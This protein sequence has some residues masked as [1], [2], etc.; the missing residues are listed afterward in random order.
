MPGSLQRSATRDERRL[1]ELD[2][3]QANTSLDLSAMPRGIVGWH[4]RVTSVP[5]FAGNALRSIASF[6]GNIQNGRKYR[7]FA[8]VPV[9]SDGTVDH[10]V[11][12][13]FSYYTIDG[14]EP[15]TASTLFSQTGNTQILMGGY[16]SE[17]VM[18]N[19]LYTS[20]MAANFVGVDVIPVRFLI[21]LKGLTAS[22][23]YH[24]FGSATWPM[25][26][27]LIDEGLDNT[28]QSEGRDY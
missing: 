2:R 11:I 21:A 20:D 27:Y 7:L 18:D 17:C 26:F 25:E 19:M 10:D 3:K 13:M 22:V 1:R 24:A 4:K 12:N 5:G 8:K 16:T 15:T 6:G 14:T 9:F 28:N 23:T